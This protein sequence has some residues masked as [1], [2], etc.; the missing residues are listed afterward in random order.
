MLNSIPCYNCITLAICRSQVNKY[1]NEY[2]LGDPE[3]FTPRVPVSLVHHL[4]FKCSLIDDYVTIKP[5]GKSI[6]TEKIS[7]HKCDEA[8][9]YLLKLD[10]EPEVC[11]S[12]SNVTSAVM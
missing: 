6:L 2:T 7:E 1:I 3:S 8:M 12:Q 9:R 4:S 5:Y 11:H 10:K